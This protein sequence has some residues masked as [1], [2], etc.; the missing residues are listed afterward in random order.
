MRPINLSVRL[1]IVALVSRYLTNQLIGREPILQRIPPLIYSRCLVYMSCG[2]SGRFQPLSPSEGQVA[3]ALL[4]R[5]P[6]KYAISA[7]RPRSHI[8][9]RLACVR[10]AA[11]VRPE[12]G[13]NSLLSCIK[14]VFQQI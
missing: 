3:H 5:P 10:H 1:P 11:S 4:A 9:V 6:L 8:S 14:S 7:R 12:P 2:I 13:S